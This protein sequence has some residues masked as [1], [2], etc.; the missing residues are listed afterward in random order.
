MNIL[1]FTNGDTI[2]LTGVDTPITYTVSDIRE[3]QSRSNAVSKTIGI[4]GTNQVNRIFGFLFDV[5]SSF[6]NFNPN[7]R[8]NCRYLE[9]GVEIL[10]GYLQIIAIDHNEYYDETNYQVVLFDNTVNFFSE[11]SGLN[12]SSVNLSAFDHILNSTN[13]IESWDNTFVDGYVYPLLDTN[14]S[15]YRTDDFKPAIFARHLLNTIADEAGFNLIGSFLDNTIFNREI[16]PYVG[17]GRI[18]DTEVTRRSFRAG[19]TFTSHSLGESATPSSYAPLTFNSELINVYNNDSTLPNFDNSGGYDITTGDFTA[20]R[21]GVWSLSGD[22]SALLRLSYTGSAPFLHSDHS[23]SGFPNDSVSNVR[24]ILSAFVNN[25]IVQDIIVGEEPMPASLRGVNQFGQTIFFP[26]FDSINTI[27]NVNFN[28]SFTLNE[29]ELNS[30]DV[31]SFE[32]RLETDFGQTNNSIQYIEL[33]GV[34]SITRSVGYELFFNRQ[35]ANVRS[36][37]RMSPVQDKSFLTDGDNIILSEFI[38]EKITQTQFITDLI[39]RYNLFIISEGNNVL[40]LETRDEYYR[41]GTT[42]D[43][44]NKK[45]YAISDNIRFAT[46]LQSKE[47][48]FTY[49]EDDSSESNGVQHNALYTSATQGDIFGQHLI[50]FD[51]DFVKGRSTIESIYSPTPLRYNE[52]NGVITPTINGKN[53]DCKPRILIY[54][55]VQDVVNIDGGSSEWVYRFRNPDNTTSTEPFEEYP[56]AGHFD[57]PRTPLF[58]NGFA[59]PRLTF[60]TNEIENTTENNLFNLYWREYIEDIPKSRLVTSY[61]RLDAIDIA[62]IKDNLNTTIQ[63]NN[64][65]YIINNIIDYNDNIEFTQVELIKI[66]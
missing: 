21:D 48:L 26:V 56:Y 47:I 60:I 30:G 24:L 66:V 58:D 12:L 35:S 1:Q 57:N 64:S 52:L 33:S 43:W 63:V 54:G 5:N 41:R 10:N 8:V 45:H 18:S 22:V 62:F 28:G 39:N 23:N 6:D 20:D 40:R 31:V 55:G 49:A 36:N 44:S 38:P 27:R 34:D 2:D 11:I 61:F 7:K 50:E 3:P 37:I 32:A 13:I 25:T 14:E 42:V 17:S 65:K 53:P 51:N 16:L 15:E 59:F 29:L 9:S 4:I 46:E 19:L